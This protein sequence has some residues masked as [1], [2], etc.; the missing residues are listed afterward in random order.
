MPPMTLTSISLYHITAFFEDLR[1]F[2]S[3]TEIP[4]R[5]FHLHFST[6]DDFQSFQNLLSYL[7]TLQLQGCSFRSLNVGLVESWDVGAPETHV[8][9]ISF[10][11]SSQDG[12]EIGICSDNVTCGLQTI[13]KHMKLTDKHNN[14]RMLVEEGV[15]DERYVDM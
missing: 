13:A 9:G 11:E 8:R 14:E 10:E 1:R 4:L 3:T 5:Y 15:V 2:L 7:M 12:Y 6:L